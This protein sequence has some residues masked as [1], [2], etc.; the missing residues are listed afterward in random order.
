MAKASF[1]GVVIAES[2]DIEI[3]DGNPYFPPDCIQRDYL[4]DSPKTSECSWK[5]TAKYYDVVVNGEIAEAA[6]WY[7]PEP[8]PEAEHLKGRVAFW[9]KVEVEK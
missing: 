1:N 7:Y 5:G 9:G 6:A 3:T 4:E 2:D 8:K